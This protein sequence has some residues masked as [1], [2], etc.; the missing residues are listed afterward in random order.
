[1]LH[2]VDGAAAGRRGFSL[3]ELMIVLAIMMVAMSMFAHTMSSAAK[4]DPVA[5]DN[6]IAAEAARTTLE[7]MRKYAFVE[8]FTRY[9]DDP[10]DDPGGNGTAPGNHFNVP[11]LSPIPGSRYVGEITFPSVGSAIREDVADAALGMPRDL[12]GDGIIDSSDHTRDAVLLPV[13]VRLQWSS[14]T[15]KGGTRT[16]TMY[17]MFAN[18]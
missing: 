14:P 9:N 16:F 10:T 12:N 2:H 4:L 1:M 7:T 18:Q 11:G 15:G 6:A 8:R 3:V 13:R 5:N 17:T